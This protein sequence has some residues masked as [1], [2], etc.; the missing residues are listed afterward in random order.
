[1]VTVTRYKVGGWGV[2]NGLR[3]HSTGVQRIPAL[4]ERR[5]AFVRL[6]AEASEWAE[7]GG[8]PDAG[9]Y[10]LPL[11]YL[12]AKLSSWNRGRVET[13][14]DAAT[15]AL[16]L[17]ERSGRVVLIWASVAGMAGVLIG[18][19]LKYQFGDS[20][21]GWAFVAVL[22]GIGITAGAQV[23]Q[24]LGYDRERDRATGWRRAMGD[25]SKHLEGA[26]P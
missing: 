17:R 25:I 15:F 20:K 14:L 4:N 13:A 5:A 7:R 8:R 26:K 24:R 10:L 19:I 11:N 22:L 16:E 23:L 1:M 3:L 21:E 18:A 12:S 6:V 2:S 9:H